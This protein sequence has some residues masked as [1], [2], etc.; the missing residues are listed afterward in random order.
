MK[1][2]G[3]GLLISIAFVTGCV[4]ISTLQTAKALDPGKQRVLVG[5]GFYT[6]PQL[7]ADTSKATNTDTT[8]ALPYMELGYR[9]GIVDKLEVGAKVTI[10]GTVGVDGKYQLV[11]A[12]GFAIAAG[13]G[14]SYL[15]ITSGSGSDEAK[16]RLIDAI[17]PAYVSY[18]I[19]SAFSLYASPKYVLRFAS[20]S[21]KQSDG[22]TMDVSGVD[23]LVG[24]S[25]GTKLGNGFGLF[26]EASYLKDIKSSFDSFQVS[27]SVFF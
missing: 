16:T 5:G 17:V 2:V 24:G 20:S 12:G 26:L 1:T 4:N 15:D 14:V 7:N 8:L 23:H 6:S 9:R 25:L 22:S 27:G 13:L 10:P 19:A 21:N 11:S 18:D 3:Q